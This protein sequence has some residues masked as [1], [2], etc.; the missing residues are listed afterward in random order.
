MT[1]AKPFQ[2]AEDDW[3]DRTGRRVRVFVRGWR[4]FD[5]WAL[6]P[7]SADR[8]PVL[9]LLAPADYPF[10]IPLLAALLVFAVTVGPLPAQWT[11]VTLGLF[12]L[13]L[14][15]MLLLHAVAMRRERVRIRLLVG[16]LA[17][18]LLVDG[19]F[20]AI[21]VAFPAAS[22]DPG[23]RP[24]RVHLGPVVT[25]SLALML[26]IASSVAGRIVQRVPGEL[27][28]TALPLVE[29]FPP[30]DRY[31]YRGDTPRLALVSIAVL[32]PLRYPVEMLLPA[33]L[34]AL[35]L[36][37]GSLLWPCV[38]LVAA[39]WFALFLGGLFDRLMEILSTVG[40]LFF[41]GPQFFL[42]LVVI[43]I[44]LARWMH[45]HYVTYLFDAP[46]GNPTVA[47]Y[48]FFAYAVAWFYGFWCEILLARR[49]IRLLSDEPGRPTSVDYDFAGSDA[50]SRVRND[51]RQIALHGAG[52][53]KV[54]GLYETNYDPAY[55]APSDPPADGRRALTFLTPAQLLEEFRTQLEDRGWRGP[56]DP[57]PRVRD[58][59]RAVLAF[60]GVTALL[61]AAFLG[62]PLYF[63]YR[64]AAQ[65]PELDVV[66]DTHLDLRL[67]PLLLGDGRAFGPAGQGDPC[68][69][70]GPYDPR[71]VVAASGGG[72]RAA[73]YTASVLR[74]LAEQG[75]ICN[76]VLTSGVSGG[77][78]ALAYFALNQDVLRRPGFNPA[79]WDAFEAAMAESY[80][81][82]V[83]NASSDSAVV[84][85]SWRP[86]H[87]VCGETAPADP[88][89]GS[90]YPSRVRFGALLA[91][92]F[93]CT[94]GPGAMAGVRFGLILNTGLVGEYPPGAPAAMSLT[95]R[96]REA[97]GDPTRSNASAG[98]RLILTNLPNPGDVGK[99]AEQSGA[100]GMRFVTINDPEMSVARAAALSANFPPVFPDAAIDE[101]GPDREVRYW[102]TDGGTVENRGTVTLYY[103]IGDALDRKLLRMPADERRLVAPLLDARRWPPL[104]VVIADVS[105][106]GGPYR[107]SFGLQSVQ[108]AGGQMGLAL[109]T[110]LLADLRQSYRAHSSEITVHALTM[111]A[112]LRDGIG[113]HWMLPHHLDFT[114]PTDAG[115]HLTL[116]RD[117]VLHLVRGLFAPPEAGLSGDA[118]TVR[119]WT[120]LVPGGQGENASVLRPQR[121]LPPHAQAWKDLSAALDIRGQTPCLGTVV[122]LG[123]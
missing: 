94:M 54:S 119:D 51:E 48:V 21:A 96:A 75:R 100:R 122:A 118:A 67:Q 98:G 104:H 111:P 116:S 58:L 59:R 66:R 36:P 40:R 120:C 11:P 6:A 62:G 44:A 46:G 101:R 86:R 79:P 41:I 76:V 71:V 73:I 45:V 108:S 53:L 81:Q 68:P 95:E 4:H 5:A 16:Y 32:V 78:A 15:L 13:G 26:W 50:V 91:E 70:L 9:Q 20:V 88:R 10:F 105:A 109:E 106:S 49:F 17:V 103:A 8:R 63:G 27:M 29:L 28:P 35:V 112:V 89:P 42:S 7:L 80:I 43:A 69:A 84:F 1:E 61:V 33:A 65:P 55:R 97:D 23:L 74:G 39:A 47:L 38:L 83:L 77:S 64:F 31:D 2:D 57:L 72:T 115:R 114:D 92:S 34:A 56:N 87:E 30:K 24:L 113:T 37:T 99:E 52:R 82:Q 123:R 121:V 110:E 60:P 102:V 85:G 93:V 14:G 25:V 107:E 12:C 90:L 3:Y 117:E 19:L 22:F 18:L